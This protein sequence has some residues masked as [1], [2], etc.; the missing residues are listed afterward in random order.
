MGIVTALAVASLLS[1]CQEPVEAPDAETDDSGT[2]VETPPDAASCSWDDQGFTLSTPGGATGGYHLG[3]AQTGACVDCWTGE[4]CLH[5]DRGL[6]HSTVVFC[7]PLPASGGR[8]DT[9]QTVDAVVEGSTT[10]LRAGQQLTYF[11]TEI[12]SGDCWIWGHDLSWFTGLGCVDAGGG[13]QGDA[14]R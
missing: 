9:V 4:D 6:D 14:H 3:M 2:Y 7:H 8:L 5:G 11:L 12:S 10:Y 13:C 1:G